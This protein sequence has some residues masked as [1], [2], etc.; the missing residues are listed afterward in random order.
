MTEQ[1]KVQ[2]MKGLTDEEVRIAQN[3]YGKNQLIPTKKESLFLKILE[4]LK[5]PMFLL[6]LV[7]AVIYF[8]L[9]EPQDGIVMLVFVSC[10]TTLRTC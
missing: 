10:N 4:V 1:K 7:A 6:L 8:I 9:G 5:E 2:T 3:K